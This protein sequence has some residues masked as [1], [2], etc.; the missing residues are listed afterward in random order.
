[1][2]CSGMTIYDYGWLRRHSDDVELC[3]AYLREHRITS[4][5]CQAAG[6]TSAPLT[7]RQRG[8]LTELFPVRSAQAAA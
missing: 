5:L 6:T 1:M 7:E 8:R 2:V 3:A 4:E